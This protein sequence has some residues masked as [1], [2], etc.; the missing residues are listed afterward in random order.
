MNHSIKG[1]G[2]ILHEVHKNKS[3]DPDSELSNQ[4]IKHIQNCFSYAVHQNVGDLLKMQ[5]AIENI[6]I[7]CLTFMTSVT[8]S[9]MIMM[10]IK[11]IYHL[12]D[13]IIL[14]Y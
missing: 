9:A 5:A 2:N 14:N 13:S 3:L 8:P 12:F 6:Q 7:I 10:K 1:I 4:N 11:K